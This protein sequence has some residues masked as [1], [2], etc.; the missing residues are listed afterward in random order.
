MST[1]NE[2]EAIEFER[3]A[4][5]WIFAKRKRTRVLCV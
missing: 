5:I 1:E 2:R 3:M 4:E